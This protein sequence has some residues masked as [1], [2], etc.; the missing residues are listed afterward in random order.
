MAFNGSGTFQRLYN[1]VTDR[2][3]SIKIRADRMDQEMDGYAAGLSNVICKDGQTTLTADLP[4]NNRKITGLGNATLAGD[5]LNQ[6]TGDVRYQKRPSTLT[7]TT[8]FDDT[9]FAGL[10]D[11]ITTNDLKISGVDFRADLLTRLRATGD[12]F[13]TGSTV[14]VAFQMTT[15]PTGWTKE[16]GAA[17]NDA[18]SRF[19]TG[20]AATGGATAFSTVFAS[21]TFTGTVGTD[22][23][24]QAKMAA[25]SHTIDLSTSSQSIQGGPTFGIPVAQSAGANTSSIGSG[26]VHNH[27]L[28][29]NAADFSV[30]FADFVIGIKT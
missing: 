12:V 28:T 29:M 10:F 11:S 16:V 9:D 17:Y 13:A 24:T 25:H 18:V 3:N 21:R 4:F 27:V 14:R 2:T 5:A 22:T 19:T 6:Q 1:W 7:A 30:K 8:T 23:P 15:P 20:T 26:A